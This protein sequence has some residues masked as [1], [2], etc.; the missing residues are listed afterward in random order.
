MWYAKIC[1]IVFHTASHLIGALQS[2][3]EGD[4]TNIFILQMKEPRPKNIWHFAI[5]HTVKGEESKNKTSNS[6]VFL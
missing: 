2:L 1:K 4:G 6:C 5:D 3:R